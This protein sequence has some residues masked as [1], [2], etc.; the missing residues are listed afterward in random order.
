MYDGY[1]KNDYVITTRPLVVVTAPGPE[2]EKWQHVFP[3]Y[4]MR[5]NVESKPAMPN[6]KHFLFGIFLLKHPVNLAYEAA[7]A[8]LND[9]NMIDPFHLEAYGQTTVNYN[10]DIEIYPVLAAMFEG[11]YGTCRLSVTN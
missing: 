4:I 6:L 1:G 7:T 10:R 3:S 11:I 2:V 8:D 5:I 9:L